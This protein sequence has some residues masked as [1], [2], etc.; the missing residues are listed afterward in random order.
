MDWI[1][2]VSKRTPESMLVFNKKKSSGE[3]LNGLS[4]SIL[5]FVGGINQQYQSVQHQKS[6]LSKA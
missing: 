2:G 1:H 5:F 6:A 3:E 4:Y